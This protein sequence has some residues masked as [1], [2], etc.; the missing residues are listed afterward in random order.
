M[1]KAILV[2][3]MTTVLL[4]FSV[5]GCKKASTGPEA[6]EEPVKTAA[7]YEAEAKKEINKDNMNQELDK[8]EQELGQE[9]SQPQ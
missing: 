4:L 9:A 8:I 5:S 6:G 1:L 7:E 2:L 3:A